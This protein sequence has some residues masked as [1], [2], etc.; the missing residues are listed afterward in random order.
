MGLVTCW[1]DTA[2]A[3]GPV[4]AGACERARTWSGLRRRCH[5]VARH[6]YGRAP[7]PQG[8]SRGRASPR[9]RNPAWRGCASCTD[10]DG[11]IRRCRHNAGG[12][13]PRLTAAAADG[14]DH[15]PTPQGTL[16]LQA[17]WCHPL[18]L[19]RAPAS[20]GRRRTCT[21]CCYRGCCGGYPSDCPAACGLRRA[22]PS[23]SVSQGYSTGASERCDS[24]AALRFPAAG[25]PV[26]GDVCV[27]HLLA[28]SHARVAPHTSSG[29]AANVHDRR[30]QKHSHAGVS[31]F[32]PLL[33]APHSG[34]G[35]APVNFL[36]EL[37][38]VAAESGALCKGRLSDN[39]IQDSTCIMCLGCS[40]HAQQQQGFLLTQS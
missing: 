11:I 12:H 38:D 29:T 25:A 17:M 35:P 7:P 24:L 32:V 13:R 34:V 40:G 2:R 26:L 23:S 28:V 33:H 18:N 39:A 15:T 22:L 36:N 6:D 31:R 20:F 21:P 37:S 27:S 16:R 1:R 30:R 10:R 5:A 19:S 3:A 8:H 4:V 9:R 14:H